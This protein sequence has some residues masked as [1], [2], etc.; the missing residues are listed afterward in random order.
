[1]R[2]LMMS[3]RVGATHQNLAYLRLK[4]KIIRWRVVAPPG[5]RLSPIQRYDVIFDEKDLRI[6]KM[7]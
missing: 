2:F 6:R 4:P 7:L 3:A 1:M 5:A